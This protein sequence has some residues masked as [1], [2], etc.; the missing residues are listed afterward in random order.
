MYSLGLSS[1]S[2]WVRWQVLVF[3]LCTPCAC[4]LTQAEWEDKSWS[5]MNLLI[6]SYSTGILR[7]SYRPKSQQLEPFLQQPFLEL[8][9]QDLR[10]QLKLSWSL[11]WS[12]LCWSF[13]CRIFGSSSSYW[14][15]K[16]LPE[17][18][19]KDGSCVLLP[20]HFQTWNKYDVK[21]FKTFPYLGIHYCITFF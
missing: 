7:Q 16:V 5:L 20:N 12:S 9:L 13:F 18:N 11:S 15:T 17:D 8:R 10:K 6:T 21:R 1:Y 4:P 3:D 2:R 14:Q 19:Y